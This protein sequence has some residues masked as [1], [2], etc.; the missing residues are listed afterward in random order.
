[1]KQ[2][3]LDD[4]LIDAAYPVCRELDVPGVSYRFYRDLGLAV[5][6]QNGVVEEL[7]IA[8]LPDY[9]SL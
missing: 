8:R 2:Q 6:V 7:V 4:I 1:M 3:E 5:L 9:K